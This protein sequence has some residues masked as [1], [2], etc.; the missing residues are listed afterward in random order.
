MSGYVG[1]EIITNVYIG[2]YQVVDEASVDI[3]DSIGQ[4]F[5]PLCKEESPH[6]D[7][8]SINQT[9]VFKCPECGVEI[10]VEAWEV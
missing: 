3:I 2:E 4:G 8:P 6:A 10:T 9:A 1:V 5:C 7:M